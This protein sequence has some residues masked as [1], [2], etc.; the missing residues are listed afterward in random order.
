MVLIKYI[1]FHI[2]IPFL[3]TVNATGSSALETKMF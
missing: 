3:K 2:I 1:L